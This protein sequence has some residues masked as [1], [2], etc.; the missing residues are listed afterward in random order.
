MSS[1]DWFRKSTWAK[2]DEDDFFAHLEK[3]DNPFHKAQYVRIQALHLQDVGNPLMLYSAIKLVEL[4]I[5]RWPEPSQLAMAYLQKAECLEALGYTKE[6]IEAFRNSLAAERAFPKMRTS[7]SL[8]FGMFAVSHE[9]SDLYSEVL[10]VLD[11]FPDAVNSP[12]REFQNSVIRSFIAAYQ[13]DADK[14]RNY[15]LEAINANQKTYSG[16][17][18]DSSTLGLIEKPDSDMH[19]KLCDIAGL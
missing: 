7:A 16:R 11:E 14:A 15:A 4:M 12:E 9:L 6:A 18:F 19:K 8:S 13:G 2:E 5:E 1:N 17:R 3:I 10:S